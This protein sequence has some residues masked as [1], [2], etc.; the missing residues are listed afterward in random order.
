M[1]KGRAKR[2]IENRNKQKKG[3]KQERKGGGNRD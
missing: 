1:G 3:I 2:R